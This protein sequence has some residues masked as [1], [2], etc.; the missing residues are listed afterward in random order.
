MSPKPSLEPSIEPSVKDSTNVEPAFINAWLK[1]LPAKPIETVNPFKNKNYRKIAR[2]LCDSGFTPEQ[3]TA[4]VLEQVNSKWRENKHIKFTEVGEK[5]PSWASIQ[6]KQ[7]PTPSSAP[8]PQSHG[9]APPI[10][11]GP[12][13]LR[14]PTPQE[15]DAMERARRAKAAGGNH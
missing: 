4:F 11:P 8:P 12:D 2:G 7:K 10:G 1:A 6:A 3:V 14:L 13:E 9:S 15:W 5:L